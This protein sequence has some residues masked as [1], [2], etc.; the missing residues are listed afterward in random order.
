VFVRTMLFLISE[1]TYE[2]YSLLVGKKVAAGSGMFYAFE[3]EV[4]I[5]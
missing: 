5:F 4:A 3:P 1:L 2:A